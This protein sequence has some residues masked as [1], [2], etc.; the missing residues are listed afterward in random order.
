MG[1]LA[2][3]EDTDVEIYR[4]YGDPTVYADSRTNADEK[5]LQLLDLLGFERKSPMPM[6]TWHELP[7]VLGERESLC[8]TRA[9]VVLAHL[10]Y[11]VNLNPELHCP[12]TERVV[13]SALDSRATAPSE[14]HEHSATPTIPATPAAGQ[15]RSL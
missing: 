7:Q 5:L 14:P 2:D 3:E 6:Y 10:G 4:R 13:R 15:A 11:T 12:Q 8:A 9:W 1:S